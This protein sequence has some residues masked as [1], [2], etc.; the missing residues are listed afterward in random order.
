MGL[1]KLLKDYKTWIFLIVIVLTFLLVYSPHFDYKYPLHADEWVHIG[2]T[3]NPKA[4]YIH[5]E[6]GYHIFLDVVFKIID[7]VLGYKF[8]PA[9][10][11]CLAS[12]ILF[13][14][15]F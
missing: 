12:V 11:T 6:A 7:P 4:S 14:F 10:F 13:Y 15:M 1:K 5:L 9:I 2:I 3:Q 8:L